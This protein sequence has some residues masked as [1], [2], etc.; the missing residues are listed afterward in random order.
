MSQVPTVCHAPVL[1]VHHNTGTVRMVM[2]IYSGPSGAERHWKPKRLYHSMS[3]LGLCSWLSGKE[4]TCQCRGHRFYSWVGKF[5]WRRNGNPLLYSCLRNPTDRGAWQAIVHAVAKGSDVTQLL[6][7]EF[8]TSLS[9]WVLSHPSRHSSEA[10]NH[11]R[12]IDLTNQLI[13]PC[14]N[15]NVGETEKRHRQE[16]EMQGKQTGLPPPLHASLFCTF[17]FSLSHFQ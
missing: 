10:E 9:A 12:V 17:L 3:S 16:G 11:H 4:S 15:S 8:F 7:N 6:N 14:S 1:M 2:E 13:F 5:L